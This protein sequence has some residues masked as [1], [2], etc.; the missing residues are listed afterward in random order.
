VLVAGRCARRRGSRF[1]V[2]ALSL[3][4]PVACAPVELSSSAV[5]TSVVVPRPSGVDD[6]ATALP[7]GP[8]PDC[9]PYVSLRPPAMPTPGD[10][11]LGSPMYDIQ[12]RGRLI[13]GV[14]SNTPLFGYRNPSNG[15][16]EGFDIDMAREVARAVF[17]DPNR[18]SFRV[19]SPARQVA[20]LA[21][22][23]VDL[24]ANLLAITCSRKLDVLFSASYF[25][26]GLR[27]MAR[28]DADISALDELG[29]RRVCTIQGITTIRQ[30][31][32]IVHKPKMVGASNWQDCLV[33]LQQ[34]QV[35][36]IVGTDAILVGLALQDSG[37]KLVG[38]PVKIQPHGL[39][40]AQSNS[41]FVR[42][43]NGVL[44]RLVADGTWQRSYDRWLAFGLGP[45]KPP[46]I[47][48][49]D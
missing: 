3:L 4:V 36:V 15:E 45:G 33:M 39:A 46:E 49:T 35:D 7:A 26:S 19:I 29:D 48:Y 25:D 11:P 18:I 20:A 14:S 34:S 27:V 41:D 16:L 43:V 31:E 5:P 9:D 1:V 38:S 37:T 23:E 22:G 17:G 28:R 2:G 12:Q 47:K 24:V 44:E 42:F 6:P 21:Q 32:E 30:I 10:M 40:V 13:V 8:E